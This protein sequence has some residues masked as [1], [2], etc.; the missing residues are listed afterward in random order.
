MIDN[1]LKNKF[2]I[3]F[4]KE[5]VS[6]ARKLGVLAVII[7]NDEKFLN[8]VCPDYFIKN[9]SDLTAINNNQVNK[10]LFNE[11]D[12]SKCPKFHKLTTRERL[13]LQNHFRRIQQ[14]SLIVGNLMYLMAKQLKKNIKD[15]ETAGIL[16]DVDYAIS[17]YNMKNHGFLSSKI[18][19]KYKIKNEIVEAIRYHGTSKY[20]KSKFLLGWAL[21][22]SEMFT[23][24]FVHTIRKYSYKRIHN[25]DFDNFMKVYDGNDFRKNERLTKLEDSS[26]PY[27]DFKIM[28]KTYD[29]DMEGFPLSRNEIFNLTK[30]AFITLNVFP[31]GISHKME[32]INL[33]LIKR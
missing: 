22:I 30:K 15:W 25:I 10:I 4:T 7:A 32:L 9:I 19:K 13:F 3:G 17:Y 8:G 20:W 1:K 6:K 29:R 24:R 5:D 27:S 21:H 16:H 12:V 26:M 2:L 11:V 18:L 31:L 28:M 33:G 23:K 14:H